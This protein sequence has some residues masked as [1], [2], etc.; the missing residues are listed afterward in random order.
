MVVFQDG[1]LVVSG[2]AP[3]AGF[4]SVLSLILSLRVEP[5][6]LTVRLEN[7][8]IGAMPVPRRALGRFLD[9]LESSSALPHGASPQEL[10]EGLT[11]PNRFEWRSGGRL[12][13]FEQIDLKPGRLVA[14]IAPAPN[15]RV[16]KARR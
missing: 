2:L 10:L 5:D 6:H 11:I 4:Q 1:R 14:R 9:R 16:G 7:C 13:R 12:I 3:A 8:R 15:R